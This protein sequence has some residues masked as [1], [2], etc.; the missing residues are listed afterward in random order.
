MDD[1]PAE[2]LTGLQ[3]ARDLE[4]RMVLP[5]QIRCVVTAWQPD[6]AAIGEFELVQMRERSQRAKAASIASASCSKE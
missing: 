4:R 3:L 2:L 6:P 1:T 5:D